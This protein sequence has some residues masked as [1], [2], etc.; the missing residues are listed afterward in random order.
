MPTTA[1]PDSQNFRPPTVDRLR[2]WVKIAQP[3]ARMTYAEGD[4]LA[5]SARADLIAKAR[6]LAEKG[7]LTT[8]FIRGRKGAPSL[9]IVQRTKREWKKGMAL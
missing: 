4:I 1:Q 8:H 7:F 3:N 6:E 2:E 5:Q 9:H